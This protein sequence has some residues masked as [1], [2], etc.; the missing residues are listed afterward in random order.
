MKRI[1]ILVLVSLILSTSS[2]C[3]AATEG[4]EGYSE[5]QPIIY[6]N[7]KWELGNGTPVILA[8]KPPPNVKRAI[9]KGSSRLIIEKGQ[10]VGIKHLD[11]KGY[12]WVIP[13][14][15]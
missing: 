14:K 12:E 6:Y 2:F 4:G 10:I 11:P 1:I 9:Y 8:A 15:K 3:M 5:G 13:S 7:G